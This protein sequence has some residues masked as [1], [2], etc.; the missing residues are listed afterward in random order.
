APLLSSW[1]VRD[2]QRGDF[3]APPPPPSPIPLFLVTPLVVLPGDASKPVEALQETYVVSHFSLPFSRYY[4]SP[5]HHCKIS[6]VAVGR[7]C[8]CS[9]GDGRVF[10]VAVWWNKTQL[11]RNEWC[12][13]PDI[14]L[15]GAT[16]EHTESS[17]LLG[18]ELRIDGSIGSE[19]LRRKRAAWAAY[20]SIREMR[21][22]QSIFDTHVLPALCS[23]MKSNDFLALVSAMPPFTKTSISLIQTSSSLREICRWNE[24]LHNAREE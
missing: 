11:M 17:V 10:T 18:R 15:H 21:C 16:L 2:H 22:F 1:A 14:P 9:V 24:S 3:L 8:V 5:R 6:P 12:D 4:Y 13:G 23:L 20:S 19:L 7:I